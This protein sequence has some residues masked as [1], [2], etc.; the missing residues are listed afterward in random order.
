MIKR[1][2]LDYFSRKSLGEKSLYEHAIKTSSY[3]ESQGQ[4][5]EQVPTT[6]HY[7]RD[8]LDENDE[9][10]VGKFGTNFLLI[11]HRFVVKTVE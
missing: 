9:N 7:A 10:D 6:S 4:I 8:D 1:K 11:I 5:K 3:D 2:K